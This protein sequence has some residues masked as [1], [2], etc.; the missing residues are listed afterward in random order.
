MRENTGLHWSQG[1]SRGN[2]KTPQISLPRAI[3]STMVVMA[4]DSSGMY[5]LATKLRLS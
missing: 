3:L 1:N 5:H 4:N 2:P